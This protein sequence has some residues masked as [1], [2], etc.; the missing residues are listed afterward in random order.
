MALASSL[1]DTSP[2]NPNNTASVAMLTPTADRYKQMSRRAGEKKTK[3]TT[4]PSVCTRP[5]TGNHQVSTAVFT[6]VPLFRRLA[7][8]VTANRLHAS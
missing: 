7:L 2:C 5:D 1:A 3:T 6:F 8:A 4:V